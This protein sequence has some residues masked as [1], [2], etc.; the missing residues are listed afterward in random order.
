MYSGYSGMSAPYGGAIEATSGAGAPGMLGGG[1]VRTS[2]PA[3]SSA[4]SALLAALNSV[5]AAALVAAAGA[6]TAGGRGGRVAG[7]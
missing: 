6:A 5:L 7:A 2:L 3:P 4:P 1:A